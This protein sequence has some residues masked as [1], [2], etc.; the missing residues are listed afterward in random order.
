MECQLVSALNASYR[1]GEP[2]IRMGSGEYERLVDWTAGRCGACIGIEK[3]YEYLKIKHY[4]MKP[5]WDRHLLEDM[6]DLGFPVQISVWTQKTGG[7][8]VCV[9]DYSRNVCSDGIT[10]FKVPN[11]HRET[12]KQMYIPK[13]QLMEIWC[14]KE[15]LG[16]NHGMWRVFMTDPMWVKVRKIKAERK[17]KGEEKG[18]E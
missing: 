7:H 10:Y 13:E 11:L 5:D 8:S 14:D 1:L 2:N 15:N 6:L 4:D 18:E 3:V 12:D 9:V 17:E 16:P